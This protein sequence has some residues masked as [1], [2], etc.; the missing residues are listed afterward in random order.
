[1]A[2]GQPF[3]ELEICML[4]ACLT[5]R[6]S[7][8]LVADLTLRVRHCLLSVVLCRLMAPI[9]D[10]GMPTV[11]PESL[12]ELLPTPPPINTPGEDAE[13]LVE[14]TQRLLRSLPITSESIATKRQLQLLR[15][16][17]N[18]P[19]AAL[20]AAGA[21]AAGAAGAGAA[22]QG[23]G[24]S[25]QEEITRL[26]LSYKNELSA[27]G[28]LI[29]AIIQRMA[30]RGQEEEEEGGGGD[31][32]ALSL[33]SLEQL[34]RRAI[35]L[36]LNQQEIA[37]ILGAG[38]ANHRLGYGGA[39]DRRDVATL[40]KCRHPFFVDLQLQR[41]YAT[42]TQPSD[43][44]EAAAPD[45]DGSGGDQQSQQQQ[46]E[47]EDAAWSAWCARVALVQHRHGPD[48]WRKFR[49]QLELVGETAH[50]LYGEAGADLRCA[51]A[52]PAAMLAS[53]EFADL[54]EA[55]RAELLA[56]TRRCF[57]HPNRTFRTCWDVGIVVLLLYVAVLIPVRIGFFIEV[58]PGDVGFAMDVFVDMV[59]VLD[60]LLNFRTGVI[61]PS[62][63]LISDGPTLAWHYLR[64]WF[65]VDLLSCL[66]ISYIALINKSSSSSSSS[67]GEGGGQ[68]SSTKTIKILRLLRLGKLLRLGRLK[69]ILDVHV[70]NVDEVFSRLIVF[71]LLFLLFS[72]THYVACFWH[73]V[74]YPGGGGSSSIADDPEPNW[75]I[76]EIRQ[77]RAD[78]SRPDQ[79]RPDE[80]I[81]RWLSRC[82]CGVVTEYHGAWAWLVHDRGIGR[83]RD[84]QR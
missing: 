39:A 18:E 37:T 42:R 24:R 82:H 10:E 78:Q 62:G 1:M 68:S 59:F 3:G 47:K 71:Q 83:Q 5:A 63:V 57:L 43:A 52:K 77:S 29:T 66:P 16:R 73:F 48:L 32:E 80:A 15:K 21:G 17:L 58:E 70:E 22:G 46:L 35:A 33:L 72:L 61:A 11:L 14:A 13:M 40:L 6:L 23:H 38:E 64:R 55:Q 79:T 27:K 26:V 56:D 75:L 30:L 36:G 4:T 69:R 8:W 67:E 54:E 41:L 19:A 25:R 9:G 76:G 28:A 84:A 51:Y 2:S 50:F 12:L 74:G 7:G 44:P 53:V 20:V 60:I 45:G 31:R 65:I 34:R 49:E 81:L